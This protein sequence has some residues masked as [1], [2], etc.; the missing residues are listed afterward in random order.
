M[1]K[2]I[3]TFC[4]YQGTSGLDSYIGM[5]TKVREAH[6][7]EL[8]CKDLPN[9]KLLTT[10]YAIRASFRPIPPG[11]SLFCAK[12]KDGKTTDVTIQYDP[13]H[14]EPSCTMF[15]AW[16][17]PVPY[18]T[19]IHLFQKGNSTYISMKNDPP[20]GYVR[21]VFSPIYVLLDPKL[22]A[23]RV[24]GITDTKKLFPRYE[25]TPQFLFTGYQERCLP[26]PNGIQLGR[27]MILHVDNILKPELSD[28]GIEPTLLN[29]L[30]RMNKDKERQNPLHNVSF[31][32]L[33]VVFFVLVV[34]IIVVM[35][36][37]R[38]N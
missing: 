26:D 32:V 1:D 38:A 12:S 7:T 37:F 13:F 16:V 15:I 31:A 27:C 20:P 29:V 24:P 10:F 17:E 33:G 21:T 9:M 35:I 6:G 5:P 11:A 28:N 8:V 34:S 36:Y 22:N 23:T 3:T 19:Q 2:D 30:R 14:I 25:N 18:T 4:A